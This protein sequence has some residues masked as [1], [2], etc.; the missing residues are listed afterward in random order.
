ML[1]VL[2]RAARM[3]KDEWRSATR[4]RGLAPLDVSQ[5][6]CVLPEVRAEG[7]AWVTVDL[8]V[9]GDVERVGAVHE[10]MANAMAFHG[11][12]FRFSRTDGDEITVE[13][14]EAACLGNVGVPRRSGYVIARLRAWA[15]VRVVL[16]G[17]RSYN[18]GQ[19]YTMA[20]Y[21]LVLCAGAR[22][23]TLPEAKVV[24]LQEDVA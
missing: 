4:I 24:D 1:V 20:D 2:V 21:H 19:V 15:P 10:V 5:V 3:R 14:D 7:L 8:N 18:S 23:E 9:S 16:N 11:A 13:I 22:P 12:V 17:R 6:V